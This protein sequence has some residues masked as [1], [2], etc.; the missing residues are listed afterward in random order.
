M[1]SSAGASR[2]LTKRAAPSGLTWLSSVSSPQ[3]QSVHSV[4]ITQGP[5]TS[6]VCESLYSHA[7]VRA[8]APGVPR[9]LL[10]AM[11]G[12][13]RNSRR[14]RERCCVLRG[15]SRCAHRPSTRTAAAGGRVG[16]VR[17]RKRRRQEGLHTSHR[18]LRSPRPQSLLAGVA[19]K[20][21]AARTKVSV[22]SLAH[23]LTAK[24]RFDGK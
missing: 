17:L 15:A 19:D 10:Y 13:A 18:F 16:S 12:D 21:R 9:A 7:S 20:R 8:S 14:G 24:R 6:P 11:G 3:R 4:S 23:A 22:Y 2:T 1:P 5:S